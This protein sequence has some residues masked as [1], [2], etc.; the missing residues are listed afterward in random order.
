VAFIHHNQADALCSGVSA[1]WD[2]MLATDLSETVT[3]LA[4]PAH[5]F[6][7]S[8]DYTVSYQL[9]KDYFER[10]KA[11]LKGFYTFDRSAHSPRPKNPRRR[12][13]SCARTCWR[14]R[15]VSLTILAR[16]QVNVCPASPSRCASAFP[17]RCRCGQ[18]AN[19][20]P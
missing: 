16:E 8:Y 3:E 10:L 18:S 11:P 6:H 15:T 9:A 2:E 4:L 5:F 13:E 19:P 1:L 12:G 17:S 14:E 20:A 7:G